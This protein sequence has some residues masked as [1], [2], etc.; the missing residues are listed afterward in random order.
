MS[1]HHDQPGAE[2]RCGKLH[3]VHLRRRHDVAGH[4]ND[5]QVAD[6][7]VEEDLRGHARIGAADRAFALLMPIASLDQIRS[8]IGQEVGVSEWILVDQARIDGL[9]T[10]T[11]YSTAASL[12]IRNISNSV[13]RSRPCRRKSKISGG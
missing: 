12:F 9:T 1:E 3:A 2:S 7:L 8:K 6:P 10:R 4:P 5:E 13:R 11:L